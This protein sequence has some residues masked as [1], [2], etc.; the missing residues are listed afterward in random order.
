[1]MSTT[2]LRLTP[3]TVADEDVFLAL[4]HDEDVKRYLLDGQTVDRA[5]VRREIDLSVERFAH[6]S[7]GLFLARMRADSQPVGFTGFRFDHQPPVLELVY[8]LLP[9]FWK[10]G[11]ATEMARAMVKLAFEQTN[12][13]VVRAAVDEPNSASIAILERLGMIVEKRST[14]AFGPMLHYALNRRRS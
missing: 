10:K 7:L 14:G 6:E 8:A 12:L 2:R 5:W 4:L 1:M 11:L 3:L 13:E 9:A